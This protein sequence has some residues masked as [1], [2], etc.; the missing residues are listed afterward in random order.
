MNSTLCDTA[1]LAFSLIGG[2]ISFSIFLLLT[3]LC[4]YI[5]SRVVLFRDF[6]FLFYSQHIV[7]SCYF[8]LICKSLPFICS[9]LDQVHLV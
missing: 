3:Y 2:S 6:L 1:S 8:F 9:I 5:S 4:L 7:G